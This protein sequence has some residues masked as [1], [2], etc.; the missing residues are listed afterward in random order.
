ME[1]N[2]KRI[3]LT[4]SMLLIGFV[5][6]TVLIQTVDVQPIGQNG[7]LVG[8]ATF[9]SWFHKLT[10]VH[11]TIYNVTDWLGLVPIIICMI[12]GKKISMEVLPWNFTKNF[13]N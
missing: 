3:W 13:R 9:N 12:I 8:F 6:W 1:K 2:G 11:M 10:N 4:G 7:T 5:I